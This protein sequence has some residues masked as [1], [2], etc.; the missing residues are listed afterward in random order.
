[1]PCYTMLTISRPSLPKIAVFESKPSLEDSAS[2]HPLF[3]SLGSATIFFYRKNLGALRP[4]PN[5]EDR[6]SVFMS[7]RDRVIQALS[8]LRL[9]RLAGLRWRYSNLPP[10]GVHLSC[11]MP[12]YRMTEELERV[13][14]EVV[15]T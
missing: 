13:S 7:P 3:N 1:V 8:F 5:L 11:I 14:K 10:H 9:L 12:N 4:T 2:L 6:F 15:V